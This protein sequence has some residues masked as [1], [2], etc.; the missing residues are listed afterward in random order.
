MKPRKQ[1][2]AQLVKALRLIANSV[3]QDDS[4][5]GVD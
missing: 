4:F 2:T 1:T 3:E 5:E